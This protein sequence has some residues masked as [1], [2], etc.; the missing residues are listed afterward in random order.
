MVRVCC[1]LL[2]YHHYN[3][4]EYIILENLAGKYKC[5]CVLDLKVGTRSY[6]DVMSPQ[7]IQEHL[8]RSASTTSLK[9]GI[10]FCGMQVWCY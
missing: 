10:R 7:K 6:N 3:N 8:D 4:I 5:P 2:Q 1:C 9:L